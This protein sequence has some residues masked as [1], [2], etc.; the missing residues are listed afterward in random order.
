MVTIQQICAI[1]ALIVRICG[2]TG[3]NPI[4]EGDSNGFSQSNLCFCNCE[5]AEQ[6]QYMRK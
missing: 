6:L 2:K 4:T 1:S 3:G 5:G